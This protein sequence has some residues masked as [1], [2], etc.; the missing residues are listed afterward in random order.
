MNNLLAYCGLVDVRLSA[1]EKDLPV[2][3]TQNFGLLSEMLKQ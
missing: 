3:E 1:S 2:T